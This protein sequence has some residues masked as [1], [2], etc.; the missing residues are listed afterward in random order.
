MLTSI[1]VIRHHQISNTDIGIRV[2]NFSE[3][4]NLHQLIDNP[5]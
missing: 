5:M 2:F 1:M 3:S 4:N